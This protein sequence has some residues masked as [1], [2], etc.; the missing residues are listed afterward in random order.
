MFK[1]QGKTQT[2]NIL[3]C[4]WITIVIILLDIMQLMLDLANVCDH[5]L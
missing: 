3:I 1:G 4:I 5:L 2:D